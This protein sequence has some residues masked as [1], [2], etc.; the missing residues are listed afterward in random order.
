[1]KKKI[2]SIMMILTLILS[3]AGCGKKNEPK[4]TSG[5]LRVGVTINP[6][7]EFAEK[8]GGD[9][10]EVFSIIP[11]GSEPHDFDPK[12]KDLESVGNSDI[13]VYNGLGM[14]EWI[15]SVLSTLKDKNVEVVDSS[16]GVNILKTDN[17]IDPHSWLSIKEA[18][19]QAENIKNA[20]VLKDSKN[21][22]YYEN[23]F[24]ELKSSFD[25]LYNEYIGKFKDLKSKDFI[26]GHAAFGYLCR[27]FGL[28]QKSI[29]DLFGEGELTPKNLEDLVKYTK[30][31]N[32]KVVFSESTASEK[33]AE[34]L[35]KEA[36]AKVEKI[37][38]L[39]TNEDNKDYLDGMRYNLDKI[40]ESNK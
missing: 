17:K 38:S 33:E 25:G 23:N 11:E 13:F 24:N 28:T 27:D 4:S 31:N 39:E 34:T 3:I 16:K 22:E 35:A 2:L 21:K 15:D 1:M 9:K 20:L 14:E 8:V 29:A 40:L 36:G 19:V 7:K 5:K 10:V 12:P 18:I 30:E 32:I 37:Y 6:L 26:T